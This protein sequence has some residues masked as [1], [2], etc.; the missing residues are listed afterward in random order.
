ML[1]NFHMQR[2]KLKIQYD[3]NNFVGWQ[4]QRTGRSVQQEIESAIE[5][6][7]GEKTEITGSSR[8]DAKVHALGQV[9]HFDTNS[10][11]P[12][13][14]FKFALNDILSDDIRIISSQK[15]ASNFN[16]RFDVKKKTYVYFLC[17][18][19]IENPIFRKYM[20]FTKYDLDLNKMKKCSNLFL[21]EHNFKGFCSSKA[22]AKTF[23]RT[24]E[25]CSIKKNGNIIKFV[26]TGN[27]FLQHMVRIIVGT[28]VDVGRG[29]LSMQ[30]VEDAL[31]NGD[32]SKSGKTMEPQGL[33][34]KRIYY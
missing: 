18:C 31:N 14:N 29:K 11:I 27:G 32:R 12:P 10:S 28:L 15:V 13:Q 1:Y 9:A 30:D 7:T 33:Y 2:I 22:Q 21:G 24:I 25:S 19:E 16:A 20:A 4:R 17:K 26:I 23:E 6:L 8:T 3:G 34:L 5:K